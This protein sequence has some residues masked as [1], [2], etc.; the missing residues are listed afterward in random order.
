[1]EQDFWPSQ[2]L[3]CREGP[4]EPMC[5]VG[6]KDALLTEAM[7]GAAHRVWEKNQDKVTVRNGERA[8]G[9]RK[10]AGQGP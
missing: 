9:I 10:S 6:T 5:W 8:E 3:G 1:M 4:C 2:M 7:S